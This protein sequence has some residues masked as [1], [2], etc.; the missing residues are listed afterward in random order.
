[1]TSYLGIDMPQHWILAKSQHA[2]AV[3][4]FGV[5]VETSFHHG[6]RCV[7][8]G[9][10]DTLAKAVIQRIVQVK[11][12]ALND[13]LDCQARW[14]LFPKWWRREFFLLVAPSGQRHLLGY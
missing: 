2:D 14:P 7:S 12:R 8:M 10:P 3:N 4:G 6:L 11:D 5:R 13:G 1:M 9:N